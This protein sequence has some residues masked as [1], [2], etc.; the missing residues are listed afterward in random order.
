MKGKHAKSLAVP[1][2]MQTRDLDEEKQYSQILSKADELFREK[3]L[4]DAEIQELIEKTKQKQ[5]EES[6]SVSRTS[7]FGRLREK[8][9]Q[10]TKKQVTAFST[11]M[12]MITQMFSPYTVLL[13]TVKAAV[14]PTTDTL[15]AVTASQPKTST[16]GNKI[17]EVTYAITGENIVSAD[18]SIGYDSTKI[19]PARRGTGAACTV[20][21]LAA[22]NPTTSCAEFGDALS[23]LDL[24]T[25][26]L[27]TTNSNIR[28]SVSCPAGGDRVLDVGGQGYSQD[29]LGEEAYG[30]NYYLPIVKL[31]FLLVDES[32]TELTHDMLYFSK[33]SDTWP[34]GYKYIYNNTGTSDRTCIDP[35]TVSY[36]GFAEAKK[37]VSSIEVTQNPTD[38]TYKNGDTLDFTGGTITIHYDDGSKDENVSIADGIQDGSITV[39]TQY[40]SNGT[41]KAV[42]TYSGKTAEIPYYV[43]SG[44]SLKTNI[45]KTTYDHGDNLDFTGGEVDLI[46]TN[47]SGAEIKE[48]VSIPTGLGN[49]TITTDTTTANVN[50]NP[51]KLTC[52]G[53]TVNLPITVNDPL[54]HITVTPPTT[55]TYDHGKDISFAGGSI[56]TYT[57]SGATAIIPATDPGIS[58]SPTKA[59]INLVA[60]PQPIAGG[61]NA[62][63]QDITVSYQGKT[64]KY[65]I[66]VN[67]TIDNIDVTTQPTAKNKYGET[68]PSFAGLIVTV[69]TAGGA[70]FTVD[71]NS[72]N[73]DKSSYNANTLNEQQFTVTYG[74]KTAP[75][76]AKLKLQDYIT[77]MVPTF[78]TTV[79]EYDTPVATIINGA[80]YVKKYASGATGASEP[81]TAGMVSGY[82][83][84]PAPTLFNSLHECSQTINIKLTSGTNSF[85]EVPITKT[86]AITMKDK[87]TGIA[88]DNYPSTMGFDYGDAFVATNGR[89]K[90]V[91][92][93][94]AK[95]DTIYMSDP[96]VKLTQTDGTTPV[97]TQVAK[98]KFTNGQATETV[99]V[100]YTKDSKNYT[101]TYDITISDKV[102]GIAITTD[103][104]KA[105]EHGATFGVGNG[106]ITVS[107][108]VADPQII[109]MSDTDVIIKQSN[110]TAINMSS[111]TYDANHQYTEH[112]KV[113]YMGQTATY[114]IVIT[115]VITGITL[116][117]SP[118][119]SYT[120]QEPI[121]N[122]GGSI[123]ITRKDGT[124]S[125]LPITDSMITGLN[126]DTVGTRQA[127]VTY[128][129]NNVTKTAKYS[130]TVANSVT[131]VTITTP[132]KT[133][134][135]HGETLAAGTVT[136]TYA[137]GTTSAGNWSD[138]TI[139]DGGTAITALPTPTEAEY[140]ASSTP[141]KISKT[142]KL[143][144]SKDGV[145]ATEV[146]YPIEIINDVKSITMYTTP[147]QNY[148][149]ND[150]I[151]V[152]GG[153]I[154]VTRAVGSEAI[155][156]TKEMTSGFDSSKEYLNNS[157]TITVTYTENNVTPAPT[158]SYKA[159]VT[160]TVA[161][162][163]ITTFPKQD[164]KYNEPLDATAG[165]LEITRSSGQK[166]TVNMTNAMITSTFDPQNIAEQTL[167]VTYGGQITTYK[168][169]VRDYVTGIT[170]TP[171][172][173]D[174]TYNQE[175]A[176]LL[177]NKNVMYTVTYAKA[178]AQTATAVTTEMVTGY[179]KTD[180]GDRDI[181]ITYTDTDVNSATNGDTFT[182]KVK[183]KTP[184]VVTGAT[185]VAPT[186]GTYKHGDP[187]KTGTITLT[188]ADGTT[189]P[190]NWSDVTITDGGT[191]I[192]AL[193][194]PT[195][196]E[197]KASSTPHKIS[198]TL[199]L[200]YSKDGV[201]AT[202]V[203][204][205]IEII[206]DVKSIT[207]YTTPKQNYS[208]N[209]VIDVTGGEIMVT[210]AVGSEAI[211]I[212]KEMTSGFDS[213]KE[214]LNN[215][216]TITV[217]YTENNVTPAPTTSYK[218]TVTDT[219]ASIKITTFPKQDYKYDE[220]LDATAGKL[221]ITRSSGEKATVNMTNAM[222]TSTFDPQNIAEQTLT[223]TYG[224]QTTTYKVTVRDYVTGITVNP[225]TLTGTYNTNLADLIQN[226]KY[227]VT[228]KAAGPQGEQNLTTGMV[229]GY[230]PTSIQTQNLTV[231]YIDTDINSGSK[232]E[233][234]TANLTV[235]LSNGVTGARIT[236]PT[237]AKYYHGASLDAGTLT[238]MNADGSETSGNWSDV[239]ITEADGSSVNMT[240]TE[241][242]YKASNHKISKTLKLNYS[243]DG[244]TADEVEYPIEIIND[245]KSIA[246]YTYPKQTYSVNDS[247]D[248]TGGEIMVTR[249]VG[250]EAIALTESMTSGFDSSQEYPDNSLVITVTY[251][252]NNVTPAPTTSYTATVTDTV[253]KITMGNTP[254]TNYKY[255]EP[256][257]TTGG[258]LTIT[259]AS[260]E[261][262][263]VDITEAMVS[264]YD[265]QNI[266]EQ[267]LTVTYG[268]QTTEYKVTVKDYV[269]G[270]TVT[271]TEVDGTY[272]Q[273]LADLIINKNIMYT[274][275]YAKAGAK[276]PVAPTEGMVTGYNKTDLGDRNITITYTDTDAD[277]ATNG[278]T[279][280][281]TV[282]VKTPNAISGAVITA[283]NKTTYNDSENL[284][285]GTITL[286]YA[287]GDTISG[288]WSDVTI[289]NSDGT[290]YTMTATEDEYKASNH[291]ISKTLKLNY[292]KDGVTADEVEYIIDIINNVKS[293][294]MY[295]E[296]KTEYNIG[297]TIEVIG[298]EVLI[299][300]A[301]GNETIALTESMTSGFDS[302]A[303]HKDLAIQVQYT[304]N[305]I[306][307]NTS[308]NINVKDDVSSVTLKTDPKTDYL[309]GE[310]FDISG[311]ELEVTRPSGNVTIPLTTDMITSTFDPQ[312]IGEQTITIEY[313]GFTLDYKVNVKDYQ[314]GIVLT[315]P[316]KTEY[317]YGEA[318]DLTGG[319]VQKVMA[320]GAATTPV[321]L[322]DTTQVTL[323]T[324]DPTKEGAQTITVDYAGEQASFAV[325]V[326]DN[327]QSIAMVD[328]PKQKYKYGEPLDISGGTILVTRTST[329][330]ETINLE[331]SM[332]TGFNPNQ[333]GEQTLTVTYKGATTDYTVEVGDYVTDIEIT[334]PN[335]EIYSLGEE[336]DLTG[337]TVKLVMASGTT[338]T[339]VDMTA[340][341]I[342]GFDSSTEGA[343]TITVTYEGF[344]KTFGISVMD[345]VKGMIL[346][347]LPNKLDYLYGESLDLTGGSIALIKES[348]QTSPI[349][350]TKDMVSGYYPNILGNQ[351]ITVTYEECTQEFIVNVK[352]FISKLQV[353]APTKTKYE[354]GEDLDL[355]GGTVGI[356]MASGKVVEETPLTASMISIFN[357]EQVGK[358][359]IAVTY[360]GL[361]GEFQVTVEDKVK[362]I[363]MN[364]L[365]NK[366]E[367]EYR[368][369]LDVTGATINVVRSSGTIVVKVTNKMVSGFNPRKSGN[370]VVTVTYEGMKTQFVVMVNA[371]EQTTP[372]IP[373]R[374]IRPV[375]P[376][377][378]VQEPEKPVEEPAPEPTPTPIP[379]PEPEKPTV[380]LGEKDENNGLDKKTVAAI[381]GGLG[382]LLL[383]ILVV[384]RRRNV[385][386][387]VEEDGEF[388]LAGT[389]KLTR[390]NLTI[391]IDQY[392]DG[393]TYH[394]KVMICLNDSISDKLDEEEIEIQHRGEIVKEKIKYLGE[395]VEITLE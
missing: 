75:T 170:A 226:V 188:Y 287:N 273:E 279:F 221:E 136:L 192:T 184:N 67:D 249:A 393:E 238:L 165:K 81:I 160:D 113:E 106:K 186:D 353:K 285:E 231:T 183:V 87:I 236:K 121:T 120:Y 213:S 257:D 177:T 206:N 29:D 258:T 330:T 145:T 91:Y 347:T 391:N 38:V 394:S 319:S 388:V 210:R 318:L 36:N 144:Y 384:M 33:V 350:M 171:T 303:E 291:K 64:A 278:D 243:K 49:Q 342:T 244:I 360:Q 40:A 114:D 228:Y 58:I 261:T 41:K 293:I 346:V 280:P 196:A 348:G 288:N 250:T 256:L 101:T 371:Q 111:T 246:M 56:T 24:D 281:A 89:I 296:P 214:Y 137:D 351:T 212:T 302:T 90:T 381:I 15:I 201:T 270:I 85:D 125:T 3:I 128:T 263:T 341:M 47:S 376:Q 382:I 73:I 116:K 272:N 329:R 166:A 129:E 208:V 14:D 314:T 78:P 187:L 386:I 198:K 126:T 74:G 138:V 156:I 247:I 335:K 245:I 112:L 194:T 141:H 300:R 392:L 315:P 251:T 20:T 333:L 150:V 254:K 118:K 161:S 216:L 364:E 223:V 316:T 312:Q 301:V 158:T 271:P 266:A 105:F 205:P 82:T 60:N 374:P 102:T 363:S 44:A 377:E 369:K 367:Y 337:A 366:V 182:A 373:V 224:G 124:T 71:H 139:T 26:A 290:P 295:Q 378:P 19:K 83:Q 12:I 326:T 169:T 151:D 94:G 18:L 218:A 277:S 230:T 72:V 127:T 147:K 28:I 6:Q 155:A 84:R 217:T 179:V 23:F 148:S 109:A 66:T 54:D 131:G 27:N 344:T 30:Y 383:L 220:P 304:E 308:Y 204:Y 229:S 52:E 39:D 262:A 267:T 274:V 336:L 62:G 10:V 200:N 79:F 334:R 307:Q 13:S 130:Y 97:T 362:G 53:Y 22:N 146:S 339:P 133:T 153:E 123:E 80:T 385:K 70:S 96:S 174:G 154:M 164:Y 298:G 17:I 77:D 51:V 227:E 387:Y 286:T 122:A 332:V 61:L 88:I 42:I 99:K 65:T 31:Y 390:N 132:S 222:I 328:T 299:T 345:S 317:E 380:V 152:T 157:L 310:P 359:T 140:K 193:P 119:T 275:T 340:S 356:L 21:K 309:Y 323:G 143:N 324:Y 375:T 16:S 331:P 379:T 162:I 149:V 175:L 202:E 368:E 63:P 107:Y 260:G 5:Y 48:V 34:T 86:Q 69:N 76:K 253:S 168:V 185:I 191:A 189:G 292:T 327:V 343:K 199:K 167:T 248:V 241:D 255:N 264:G 352:D 178:G 209:D 365:P 240:P 268:G 190:G 43:L 37:A 232:D 135:K 355:T 172:E 305:G 219:V 11:L 357:N 197:Y 389:E 234:F 108:A 95:G 32:I 395:P 176:D 252:E 180:L 322:S 4:Q 2:R 349:P 207:M 181:T 142:L 320:S 211:A 282:K 110:G 134:Y 92:A 115:N 265:P 46:F 173:V 372:V 325:T 203:S 306:T 159:T 117:P 237:N 104:T 358:Q 354:Y 242:E 370:Q 8:A 259:R 103:P 163:K 297:D 276:D 59:D 283:P 35:T 50:K 321:D 289:T 284:A 233:D 98:S 225:N 55:V 9:K 195:E 313:G 294:S 361:Q 45:T 239:T 25:G 100:T 1:K 235:T 93:S 7:F 68:N 269:T 215:S 338:T 57:K 311:G